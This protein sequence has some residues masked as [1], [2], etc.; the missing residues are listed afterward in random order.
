MVGRKDCAPQPSL[1]DRA[2]A[3]VLMQLQS[4]G[5]PGI[6]EEPLV[7][8]CFALRTKSSA[9][10]QVDGGGFLALEFKFHAIKVTSSLSLTPI[11]V[12]VPNL[13]RTEADYNAVKFVHSL[14][15]SSTL[16]QA[17]SIDSVLATTQITWQEGQSL[18]EQL[19]LHIPQERAASLELE[20]VLKQNLKLKV[21]LFN[22]NRKSNTYKSI[23]WAES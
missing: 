7:V 17:Q 1:G 19:Q 4:Q 14:P 2:A 15:A 3:Q 5:Y 6:T 16:A 8:G 11:A 20:S 21:E 23:I 9:A 12:S 22:K 10:G 18:L 13:H